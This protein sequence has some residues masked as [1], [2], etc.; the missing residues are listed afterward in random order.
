MPERGLAIS[1]VRD[2]R[3]VDVIVEMPKPT[4]GSPST[5]VWPQAGLAYAS[6]LMPASTRPVRIGRDP[7]GADTTPS[8]EEAAWDEKFM[9]LT[10]SGAAQTHVNTTLAQITRE[11]FR[12]RFVDQ[13]AG[14]HG[15]RLKII[16]KSL[17]APGGQASFTAD[18]I[19]LDGVTGK[20]LTQYPNLTGIRTASTAVVP[21]T[22]AGIII[23]LAAIA[24]ADQIR[25]D[26]AHEAIDSASSSFAGWLLRE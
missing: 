4:E 20:S 10:R 24:I 17:Q 11:S 15:A 22:P 25:G 9:A 23:G 21:A 26:P 14:R 13:P 5:I 1:D 8:P 16:V 3:I 6:T 18:A 2:L 12:K 7:T 19:L